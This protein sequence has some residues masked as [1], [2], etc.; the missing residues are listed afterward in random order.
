MESFE[1]LVIST[2]ILNISMFIASF[3]L[4]DLEHAKPSR[5]AFRAYYF[6]YLLF[7][8]SISLSL[9]YFDPNNIENL[10]SF[11]NDVLTDV[12]L[13]IAY[14]S[15]VI[16]FAWRSQK[17]VNI[18]L[19]VGIAIIHILINL[20][21]GGYDLLVSYVFVVITILLAIFYVTNRKEKL[22]I[23][24]KG[25]VIVLYFNLLTL[26][27]NIWL[28]N[29]VII[30]DELF[31]HFF[32]QIF[33]YSPASLAVLTL[34]IFSSYFNDIKNKLLIE[35][36]TD[37]MTE[38][39][40]RRYFFEQGLKVLSSA[41]RKSHSTSIIMCDIDKFKMVNDKFGHDVGDKAIILFSKVLKDS[42]R[43]EDIVARVG[44]E[45]FAIL[46]S[47][48]NVKEAEQLAERVRKK[49]QLISIKVGNEIIQFTASFGV[50][51][52]DNTNMENH[53]KNA[54]EA[55]YIAKNNGRNKVEVY[56]RP[57]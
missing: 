6:A 56:T 27:Y 26:L 22:N 14:T 10:L 11:I 9:F 2:V 42:V 23:G 20:F 1:Y 51:N 33:V 40:N 18:R 53:L 13:A 30:H 4:E 36:T 43:N 29:T 32:L 28:V 57:T 49:T 24:D 48:S 46:L 15:L 34:F 50:S 47:E 31:I 8:S 38:L 55:L 35:A 39:Y 3:G 16:A 45:E 54:D 5:Y 19:L 17:T 41:K 37:S 25:V 52:C 7:I 44:G 21:I 12:F